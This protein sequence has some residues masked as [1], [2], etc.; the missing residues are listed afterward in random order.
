MLQNKIKAVILDIGRVLVE[1]NL[2]KGIFKFITLEEDTTDLKILDS[3]LNDNVFIDFSKGKI[4]PVEFYNN[5]V[6]KTNIDLPYD[7]FIFHWQNI[8]APIAG[9]EELT[10]LLSKKYEI[11]ILSDIDIL[12]WQRLKNELKIFKKAAKP[13]LSYEVGYMKPEREIYNIAAKNVNQKPE[14]CLFID[15]REPNVKGAIEAGMH[16]IQFRGVEKLKA[17]LAQLGI[18]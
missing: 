7:D 3:L 16:A 13:T 18:I 4:T 14:N 9:M 11:G 5:F 17:D 15:D 8:F 1:V 12:H 2:S 10:E 6:D